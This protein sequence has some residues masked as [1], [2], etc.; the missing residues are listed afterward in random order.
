MS[1]RLQ[2]RETFGD[3]CVGD[4]AIERNRRPDDIPAKNW[5]RYMSDQFVDT[6]PQEG[7][8]DWQ[9]GD[10]LQRER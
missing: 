3:R 6:V 4:P 9:R 8:R 7:R 1:K 5:D 10:R 2:Q